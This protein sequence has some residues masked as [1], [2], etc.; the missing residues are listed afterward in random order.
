MTRIIV[1]VG[2]PCQENCPA[3]TSV[4]KSVLELANAAWT[5]VCIWM[6]LDNSMGNSLSLGQPIPG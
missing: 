2:S 5:G 6:H 4:H 1:V 3:H